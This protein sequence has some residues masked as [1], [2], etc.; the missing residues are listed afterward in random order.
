MVD[1]ERKRRPGDRAS[2]TQKDSK[3]VAKQYN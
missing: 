3:T 1:K 2:R